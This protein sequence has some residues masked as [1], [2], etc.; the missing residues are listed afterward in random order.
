[1]YLDSK[2]FQTVW[3]LAHN[4]VDADP[5]KS[6]PAALPDDLKEAI[7]RL[8]QAA[9]SQTISVRTRKRS[10]FFEE[11]FLA[12]IFDHGHFN[13]FLRCLRK[14]EFDKAY[15]DSVYVKRGDILRWCQNEFLDPP[16]I[17][18]L[19]ETTSAPANEGV[20]DD[21]ATEWYERLTEA[22]KQRVT[23][24]EMAKKLWK[25]NPEQKYEEVFRH[26]IMK[27]YG[28]PE[29]FTLNAFKK[30]AREFAPEYAKTGGRPK[31]TNPYEQ[32]KK[33]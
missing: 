5:D 23:C 18:R 33:R 1:M 24:L 7:H 10:F 8:M 2:D 13:R 28:N 31:E 30:W 11:S 25:I 9:F 19:A 17:W 32:L 20:E 14:D 3:R 27:Q 21:E 12:S 6:D 15:L 4:W 22:R 26:P 16:P 29:V